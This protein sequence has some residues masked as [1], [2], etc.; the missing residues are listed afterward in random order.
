M[1]REHVLITGGG[2]GLGVAVVERVPDDGWRV[3]VPDILPARRAAAD[4]VEPSRST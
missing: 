1:T 2:G 4:A 3:V